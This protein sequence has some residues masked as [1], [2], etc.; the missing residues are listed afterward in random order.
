MEVEMGGVMDDSVKQMKK[1]EKTMG[2]S[3]NN[4]WRE[5][6][7]TQSLT[8]MLLSFIRHLANSI[9]PEEALEGTEK[10]L[11]EMGGEKSA[12]KMGA[13]KSAEKM[14]AEKSTKKMNVQ[15]SPELRWVRINLQRRWSDA[16]G[17]SQWTDNHTGRPLHVKVKTL[18]GFL[19]QAVGKVWRT[20][21]VCQGVECDNYWWTKLSKTTEISSVDYG[22]MRC[23]ED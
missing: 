10:S 18:L 15:K 22:P 4:A 7:D 23:P 3:S 8:D 19:I 17:Y 21:Q 6:S 16:D 9:P 12:E 1:E 11:D 13:E 5:I 14:S 2:Q 20:V